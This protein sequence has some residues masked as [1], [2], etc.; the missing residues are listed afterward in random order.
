M[1]VTQQVSPGADEFT[2]AGAD[3]FAALLFSNHGGDATAMGMADDD[4]MLDMQFPDRK[5]QRCTGAV[6]EPVLFEWRHQS[7]HI[8][9]G[10]DVARLGLKNDRRVDP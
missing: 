4:D 10:E 6:V 3:A 1:G 9:H 7:G 2:F 5:F 8:T